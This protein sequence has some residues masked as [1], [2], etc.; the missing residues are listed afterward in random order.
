MRR[1]PGPYP[2][3]SEPPRPADGPGR[4]TARDTS[5][6]TGRRAAGTASAAAEPS[7]RAGRSPR[8]EGPRPGRQG[9][10]ARRDAR[11]PAAADRFDVADVPL[12]DEQR[13]HRSIAVACAIGG[14]FGA[15][16]FSFVTNRG[17]GLP[18]GFS[19]VGGFLIVGLCLAALPFPAPKLRGARRGVRRVVGAGPDRRGEPLVRRPLHR[20]DRRRDRVRGRPGRRLASVPPAATRAPVVTHPIRH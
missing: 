14:L 7:R 1:S 20:G 18:I 2:R 17:L 10:H 11:R 4:R 13:A 6:R 15:P 16:A 12:E 9:H 8:L 3:R 5:R 19:L